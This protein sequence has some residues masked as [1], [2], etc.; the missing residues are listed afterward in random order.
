MMVVGNL[1]AQKGLTEMLKKPWISIN[2]QLEVLL[3]QHFSLET[4]QQS[5]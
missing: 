2:F 1:Y 5:R 3:G 4:Q